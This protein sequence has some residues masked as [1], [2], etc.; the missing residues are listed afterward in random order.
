MADRLPK[1]EPAAR[2]RWALHLPHHVEQYLICLVVHLLFPL[3]PVLLEWGIAR[4]VAADTLYL[5]AAMYGVTI[6]MS[7]RK[8]LGMVIGVVIGVVFTAFYAVLA[9]VRVIQEAA[10]A[11]GDLEQHAHAAHVSGPLIPATAIAFV[12]LIHAVERY[13]RHISERAPYWTIMGGGSE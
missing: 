5:V 9:H 10:R 12:F 3:L 2:P 11:A 7:S 4:R 8:G 13:F 6:G 1:V